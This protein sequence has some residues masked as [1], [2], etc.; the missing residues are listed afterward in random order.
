MNSHVGTLSNQLSVFGWLLYLHI[1]L[2][3]CIPGKLL[4]CLLSLTTW[5]IVSH[6]RDFFMAHIQNA[7]LDIHKHYTYNELLF[8]FLVDKCKCILDWKHMSY[9]EYC[10]GNWCCKHRSLVIYIYNVSLC[11]LVSRKRQDMAWRNLSQRKCVGVQN[12]QFTWLHKKIFLKTLF[13]L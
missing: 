5:K 6:Q 3:T 12:N 9:R 4:L 10:E 13:E 7:S 2:I 11:T 8:I 1:I